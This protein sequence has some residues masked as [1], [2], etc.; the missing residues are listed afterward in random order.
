M[1]YEGSCTVR[2]SKPHLVLIEFILFICMTLLIPGQ[3][4]AV[5]A[6]ARQKAKPCTSC[7]FQHFPALNEFGRE[8]RAEG[9]TMVDEDEKALIREDDL[10]LPMV[11]NASLITKLRY[12]KTNGNTKEGTDY[13]V[14]EWPDEA[15]LMV[16]G[17]LAESAGFLMELGLVDAN[18]FLSTKLHFNVAML[19]ETHLS[20]IPFS[21]DGLGVAYG[22]ELLNTGAQRSQ[23]PIESRSGYSA[24]QALGLGSGEATGIALVASNSHYFINYSPWVPGWSD[25]NTTVRASGLSHYLRA[26]YTTLIGVADT[27]FGMQ[28]W[29][30]DATAALNDGTGNT[31]DIKTDGWIVDAQV[32]TTVGSMPLGM[33]ASYGSCRGDS[34]HFAEN[35]QNTDNASAFGLLVQLGFLPNVTDVYGAYRTMDVGTVSDADFD[36]WVL[37]MNYMYTPNVRFELSYEKESGSGVRTRTTKQDDRVIFQLFAGF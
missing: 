8:F 18:S 12:N 27:G 16:G 24:A 28:Y 7:H 35:C 19:G 4:S 3:A 13:G 26:A 6:F 1:L 15:A 34:G 21:T 5:P 37:G 32:Q 23:R 11:L 9:Y 10:S 36:V 20:V 17:R 31:T 29:T 33:Y 30:G 22:F 25:T 14:I 2:Y